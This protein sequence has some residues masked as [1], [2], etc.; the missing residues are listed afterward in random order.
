MYRKAPRSCTATG[1]L[2][3]GFLSGR[4]SRERVFR[5]SWGISGLYTNTKVIRKCHVSLYIQFFT[6]TSP[7]SLS[8]FS[9]LL[10]VSYYHS[11]VLSPPSVLALAHYEPLAALMYSQY[12]LYHISTAAVCKERDRTWK[13][14]G[15]GTKKKREDGEET[16]VLLISALKIQLPLTAYYPCFIPAQGPVPLPRRTYPAQGPYFNTSHDSLFKKRKL[17]PGRWRG[18]ERACVRK[19]RGKEGRTK[20]VEGDR[21]K[22]GK[23][24]R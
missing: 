18:R 23:N 15:M 1:T 7:G 10:C 24:E 20:K 6:F 13:S 5:M 17:S 9:V 22:R 3:V 14:G 12:S 11:L 19:M 2:T 16:F 8:P 21:M 4:Y